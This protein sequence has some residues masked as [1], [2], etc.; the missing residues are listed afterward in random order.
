MSEAL[1]WAKRGDGPRAE[2]LVKTALEDPQTI[3]HTHHS[4]HNIAAVYSLLE[5][6]AEA[7]RWLRK[8]A[9][10]GLPN[11]PLF[12]DDAHLDGL[13]DDPGFQRLMADLRQEWEEYRKEFAREAP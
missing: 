9:G 10:A 4:W 3:A 6:P 8:A 1:L 5:R 12:R 2:A 13:R 11:Y 7:V